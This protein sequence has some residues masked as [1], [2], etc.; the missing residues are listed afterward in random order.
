[1]LCPFSTKVISILVPPHITRCQK[2][3]LHIYFG[4]PLEKNSYIPEDALTGMIQPV[5]SNLIPQPTNQPA[6]LFF[7]FTP[8]TSCKSNEYSISYSSSSKW[9]LIYFKSN[10]SSIKNEFMFSQ[11]ISCSNYVNLLI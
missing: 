3:F 4:A 10:E 5:I 11:S 9:S 1:M 6:F 2:F 7:K 8:T